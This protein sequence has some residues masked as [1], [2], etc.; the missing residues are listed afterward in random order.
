M[1]SFESILQ[2]NNPQIIITVAQ[3]NAKEEISAFLDQ[4]GLLEG[5]DYFYF[6]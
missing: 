1:H 4:Q 6:R 2:E 3:R 5:S